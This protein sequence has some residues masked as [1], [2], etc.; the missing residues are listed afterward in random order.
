MIDL[1]IPPVLFI[2]LLG[3]NVSYE[4][5]IPIF[6]LQDVRAILMKR[7]ADMI[8]QEYD[9]HDT[10]SKN[11]RCRLV[12][13]LVSAMMEKHGSFFAKIAKIL[14]DLRWDSVPATL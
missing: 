5:L 4:S 10:L 1:C 2:P 8:L 11:S 13:I 9:T 7:G 6:T 3:E 12:R 14:A